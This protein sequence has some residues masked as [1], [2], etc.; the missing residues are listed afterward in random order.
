[1]PIPHDRADGFLRACWRGPAA[2]LD[3]RVSAAISSCWAIGAVSPALRRLEEDRASGAWAERHVQLL[4][5]EA[6]GCG[7]RLVVARGP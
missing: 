1:V 3:A 4:D 6:C 5:R 7:Y 2:Y